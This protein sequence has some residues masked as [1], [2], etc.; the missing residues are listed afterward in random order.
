MTR[1]ETF[2]EL[3]N[4]ACGRWGEADGLRPARR[5]RLI[6]GSFLYALAFAAL[7]GLAAG[8]RAGSLALA[9]VV[10]VPLV[11]LLS[12]LCATPAGLL[13]LRLS[14]AA[15]RARDLLLWFASAVLSGT[16]V[17]A[18]LAPL[19]AVYTHTSARL[20]SRLATASV[21]VAVGV[22]TA[23]F[24][25]NVLR[26]ARDRRALVA[27]LVLVA[28]LAA[29]MVQFVALAAPFLADPTVFDAGLDGLLP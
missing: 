18:V 28:V 16:L 2:T 10:K 11:V 27:A 26:E 4:L 7:W 8:S 5:G 3:M 20:G 14:G 23:F 6:V 21:L 13:A 22:A 12:S 19:V 9:N 15:V 17:L 1:V 25:R 24:V 29:A